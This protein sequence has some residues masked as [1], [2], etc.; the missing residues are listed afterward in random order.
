MVIGIDGREKRIFIGLYF[1]IGYW[2]MFY[3][4]GGIVVNKNIVFV[5]GIVY[6]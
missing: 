1:I 2:Y 4:V 3:G 5:I 6:Y